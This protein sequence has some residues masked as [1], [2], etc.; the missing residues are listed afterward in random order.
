LD[1]MIQGNLPADSAGLEQWV[2]KTKSEGLA[3]DLSQDAGSFS[4]LAKNAPQLISGVLHQD[5]EQA[6]RHAGEALSEL[7]AVPQES[8]LYSSLRS[9]EF[10]PGRAQQIIYLVTPDG[11][12][13]SEKR[14]VEKETKEAAHEMSRQGMVRLGL[15]SL[16]LVAF[17]LFL[18][19]FFVDYRL[20]FNEA[21]EQLSPL[22]AGDI[23][24]DDDAVDELIEVNVKGINQKERLIQFDLKKGVDWDALVGKAPLEAGGQSW[25]VFLALQAVAK[26]RLRCEIY[27]H[28]GKLLEVGEILLGSFGDD[29]SQEAVVRVFSKRKVARVRIL[30]D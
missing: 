5:L 21:K 17:L 2:R 6:V 15:G 30:A 1:G 11:K 12:F 9:E 19:S 10:I 4:V 13:H 23:A 20:I 7:F 26:G 24:L 16:G 3:F 28:D 29:E 18:S 8:R 27:D 25:E 14:N 22:E